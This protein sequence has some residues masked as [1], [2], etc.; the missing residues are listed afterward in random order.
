VGIFESI[1]DAIFGKA[2]AE[3]TQSPAANS[4]TKSGTAAKPSA[5]PSAESGGS[6]KPQATVDVASV[7]NDAVA[8]KK[9]KLNWRSSIV[10][11]MKALDLDSSLEARKQLARELQYTGDTNDSAKM[12]VWLHKALM[13]KLAANGGKVPADLRD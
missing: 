3:P 12:N 8:A 7:L 10:D 2:H 1:S 9:Q 5:Q 11:L 6:P 13:T 4:T